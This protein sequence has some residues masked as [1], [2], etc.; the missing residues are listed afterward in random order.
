MGFSNRDRLDLIEIMA[1]S[2]ESLGAKQIKDMFA[3]VVLRDEFLVHVGHHLR[4]SALAQR[5]RAEALYAPV[6][7]GVSAHQYARRR[8]AHALQPI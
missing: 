7:P 5:G 4:V 1:A 3:P 8:P 6:H 2:E